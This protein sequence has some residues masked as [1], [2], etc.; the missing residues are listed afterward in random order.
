MVLRPLVNPPG[1]AL[2]TPTLPGCLYLN[3]SFSGTLGDYDSALNTYPNSEFYNYFIRRMSMP[4]VWLKNSV[5][6]ISEAFEMNAERVFFSPF[7]FGVVCI[8]F[9]SF[10]F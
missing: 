2:L 10:Y 7:F 6:K 3:R 4:F 8:F 5:R 1:C 9:L